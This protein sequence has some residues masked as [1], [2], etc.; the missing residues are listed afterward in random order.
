MLLFKS[1]RISPCRS[2]CF[3]V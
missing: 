2:W 3:N 1:Y